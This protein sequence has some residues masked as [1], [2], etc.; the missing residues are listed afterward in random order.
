MPNY[1]DPART[2]DQVTVTV[3]LRVFDYDAKW[4]NV[5]APACSC[6]R[7]STVDPA[8]HPNTTL[9]EYWDGWFHVAHDDGS[10]GLMDGT[11]MWHHGDARMDMPDPQAS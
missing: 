10:R 5:E 4:G 11:R 8:A 3:G 6:Q 1:S 7:S 2:I 9:C